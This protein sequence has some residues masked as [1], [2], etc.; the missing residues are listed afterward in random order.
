MSG[1]QPIDRFVVGEEVAAPLT[2]KGQKRRLTPQRKRAQ[3]LS[4]YALMEV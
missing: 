3:T 1:D 2:F 4:A